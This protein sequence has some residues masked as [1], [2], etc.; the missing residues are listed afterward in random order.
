VDRAL[1]RIRHNTFPREVRMHRT[2]ICAL[3]V[4]LVT[5]CQTTPQAPVQL[6]GDPASL[7]RLAG[8]W[9]GQYWGGAGG[10]GGSLS[11]MLKS[12]SDSLYGDVAMVDPRG[13]TIRAADPASVHATHV[14]S[15]QHLRIDFVTIQADSVRGVL[16]P[17]VAP[18]CN[19]T[20][21]T[22][23]LGQLRGNE[24]KGTFQTRSGGRVQ[25]EGSWE[26]KRSGV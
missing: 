16:E 2:L 19:C 21:S 23:F 24:I 11:F 25:A 17:Y 12:G 3:A 7:A 6:R 8:S 20:V 5:G 13:Q 10:R 15:P 1:T 22:T 26:M 4:S 9:S 14:S 18:D